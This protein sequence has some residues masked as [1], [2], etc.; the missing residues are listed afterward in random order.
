MAGYSKQQRLRKP[1]EFVGVFRSKPVVSSD[2]FFRVLGKKSA[3]QARLGLVVS[4]KVD[5]RAVERNR[6]KR[7]V[8][9]IF[10]DW[11]E[12]SDQVLTPTTADIVFQ[13]KPAAAGACNQK[14]QAATYQHL[15][16]IQNQ[17]KDTS[18]AGNT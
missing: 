15:I 11:N 5:K 16:N 18:H 8:R 4:K 3:A 10:R 9:E 7:M 14:L 17:L 6:I 13:A 12:T 1:S 2:R